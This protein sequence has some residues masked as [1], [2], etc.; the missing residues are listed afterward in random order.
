LEVGDRAGN[1]LRGIVDVELLV[2]VLRNRLDFSAEITLNVVKV[3]TIIPIDEIYCET[4]M[5]ETPRSTNTMKVGFGILG[6]V[7]VDNNIDG[8]D[9]DTTSK[10]I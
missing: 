1:V 4:K 10:E 6:E 8:L 7:K 3:E 9:V 2:N 5:S